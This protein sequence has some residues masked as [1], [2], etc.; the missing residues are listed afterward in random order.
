MGGPRCWD[1]RTGRA[2]TRRGGGAEA[3]P[4]G[5]P[6]CGR[7]P[8]ESGLFR[9]RLGGLG[10]QLEPLAAAVAG[11]A[12]DAFSQLLSHRVAVG[13]RRMRD[14]S[15]AALTLQRA[16]SSLHGLNRKEADPDT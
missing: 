9:G 8:A 14:K 6:S 15:S 3:G 5:C 7:G 10:A 2:K 1:G 11:L 16:G 12:F 13:S 4:G